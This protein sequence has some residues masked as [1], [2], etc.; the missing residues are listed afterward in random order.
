M[1]ELRVCLLACKLDAD[2][3]ANNLASRQK[4]LVDKERELTDKEKRLAKKQLQELAAV[5]KRLEELQAARA[6]EAQKV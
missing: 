2:L 4:V 1:G 6:V 5:R 3:Q